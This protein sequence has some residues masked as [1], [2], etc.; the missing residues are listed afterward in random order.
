MS[1]AITEQPGSR[2]LK[3]FFEQHRT[4]GAYPT[5]AYR[6]R[7]LL[8]AIVANVIIYYDLAFAG[9]LPLWISSLHFTAKQFGSF[10]SFA[11][12]LAGV[13]GLAGG[14]LADRHGRVVVLDLCIIAE[15][16]LSFANLLMTGYWSFVLIRGLMFVVA[17]LGAP[18]L[19]SLARDFTPRVGRGTGYGL[20]GIGSVFSQWV[21][22]LIPGMTLSRFPTWQAQILIMSSLG[23]VL[24]IPVLLLL[25]DVHPSFRL[26][27]IEN[28]IAAARVR[29]GAGDSAARVPKT[30]TAAFGTLL[31]RWE[32]WVL[33][34]GVSLLIT[35]PIT[36]QTFGPLMFVQVFKYTPAEAS[37]MASY[38]FLGQTLLYF[39][40]GYFSDL[41]RLRKTLSLIMAVALTALIAW[42]AS[43]FAQPLGP[44]ALGVVNFMAGGIWSLTYVP[45]AAFYSEYL[46]DLSPALQATG[47]AFFHATF[48]FWLAL[49]GIL[50]PIVAQRYG[51]G[52]WI[53]IVAIAVFVYIVTL[54]V[55]PGHWRRT[56][57]EGDVR[58]APAR[59]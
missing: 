38:F 1:A 52:A 42:W 45:W 55:V 20:L 33:V 9:I 58:A 43:T 50:Q 27:V 47:W 4:L 21:W 28:D 34:A 51:W 53:W 7:L 11:V 18:A 29:I 22:A 24:L 35:V 30:A 49:A 5:G 36:M 25:K 39:P 14:P 54:I 2:G 17:G 16:A 48:R 32:I 26:R 37:K 56:A 10:L 8:L 41:I 19:S 12:L 59:A 44:F 6:Y 23:M 31:C 13:A 3:R 57:V 15:L 40:S 46:E